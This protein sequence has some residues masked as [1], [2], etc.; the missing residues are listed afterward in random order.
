MTRSFTKFY[1]R[2]EAIGLRAGIEKRAR[3]HHVTLRDLYDGPNRAPSITAA[4][5]AVYRW[6][7][8]EGKG[9]NEIARLFDRTPSSVSN[10]LCEKT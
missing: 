4:R 10:L 6:L 5:R 8:D 1:V 3:T 7:T 2:I 9:N